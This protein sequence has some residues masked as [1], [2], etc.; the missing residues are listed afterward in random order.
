M[1]IKYAILGL[2]SWHPYTGYELKKAFPNIPA[3]YWSGNNNQIYRTLVQLHNEKLVTRQIEIQDNYPSKKIY[4]ITEKGL[5]ELKNWLLTVPEP[6]QLKNTFMIKLSFADQLNKEEIQ[7]QLLD[8]KNEIN[9]QI[10]I[11]K[12]LQKRGNGKPKR[13]KRETYLWE[14]IHRRWISYYSNELEWIKE[15]QKNIK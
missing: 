9:S 1:S 15:L 7:K 3:L 4:T 6:P 11:I 13:G 14:M 8:Y 10:L 5:H 12:E 2:L